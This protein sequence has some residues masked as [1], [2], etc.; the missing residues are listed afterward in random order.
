[1]SDPRAG[2][3]PVSPTATDPSSPTGRSRSA[4]L[5]GVNRARIR[6]ARRPRAGTTE[7]GAEDAGTTRAG[8]TKTGAEDAGTGRSGGASSGSDRTTD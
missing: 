7:T 4:G 2:T 8:T 5:T 3:D 6:L 1:L